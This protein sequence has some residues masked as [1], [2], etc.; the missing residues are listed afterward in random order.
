MEMY[1]AAQTVVKSVE[2]D[3]V[4][5]VFLQNVDSVVEKLSFLSSC[6]PLAVCV[7]F[8]SSVNVHPLKHSFILENK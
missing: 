7:T 1:K 6:Q 3:D 8:S 4:T 2:G 5:F